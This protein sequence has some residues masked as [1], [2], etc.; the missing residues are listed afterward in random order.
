MH[1]T[2]D[3]RALRLPKIAV[4][5]ARVGDVVEEELE[6]NE[7]EQAT[8]RRPK[9][10]RSRRTRRSSA[11]ELPKK[12]PTV[13]DLVSDATDAV[14]EKPKA[15][16]FFDNLVTSYGQ[17]RKPLTSMGKTMGFDGP[18]AGLNRPQWPATKSFSACMAF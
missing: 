10:M 17:A 15:E 14:P 6:D 1:Q 16:T 3:E 4:A 7:T 9:R 2:E 18:S 5:Y 8:H 11:Q 12:R 13:H